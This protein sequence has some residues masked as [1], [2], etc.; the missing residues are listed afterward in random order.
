MLPVTRRK[1][2]HVARTVLDQLSEIALVG[3]ISVPRGGRATSPA[4]ARTPPASPPFGAGARA[5]ACS[6]AARA[7]DAAVAGGDSRD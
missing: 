4:R 2:G 6:E 3:R 5:C 1:A 7:N